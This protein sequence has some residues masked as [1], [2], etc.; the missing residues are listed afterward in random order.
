MRLH[1]RQPEELV[2][3]RQLSFELRSPLFQF[4]EEPGKLC[5]DLVGNMI[6][7]VDMALK[8]LDAVPGF[9]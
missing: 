1:T 6:G 5:A 8:L 7:L 2:V 9:G 4:P 3:F